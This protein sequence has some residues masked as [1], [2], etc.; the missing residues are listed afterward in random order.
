V[1]LDDD[2]AA[3][4]ERLRRDRSIGLNEAVNELIRAGLTVKR[5]RQPFRQQA[6]HIG[7]RVDVSN[8]AEALELLEGPA[9]R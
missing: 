4:V 9:A 1:T 2:V 7:F 3:A 8:V 5:P 6:E